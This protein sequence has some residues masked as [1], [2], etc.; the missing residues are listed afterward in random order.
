M[1]IGVAQMSFFFGAT[2]DVGRTFTRRGWAILIKSILIL[3]L[4]YLVDFWSGLFLIEEMSVIRDQHSYFGV[5]IA[6]C[7]N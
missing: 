5:N 3:T 2:K 7:N 6:R 1:I 4:H